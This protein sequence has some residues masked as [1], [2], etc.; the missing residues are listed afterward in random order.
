MYKSK[1]IN[2]Y[3]I[4]IL[5]QLYYFNQQVIRYIA[6]TGKIQVLKTKLFKPFLLRFEI[7]CSQPKD[8]N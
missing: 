7:E 2:S 4:S 6:D 5:L 8:V 3:L 1:L